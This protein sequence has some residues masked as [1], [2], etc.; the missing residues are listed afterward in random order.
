MTRVSDESPLWQGAWDASAIPAGY[1]TIEMQRHGHHDRSD[2]I[3]VQVIGGA[4]NPPVAAMTATPFTTGNPLS[5]APHGV[6]TN[7]TDR[8]RQSRSR[9]NLLT[10]PG[11]GSR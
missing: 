3:K 11:H 8:R 5:V 7:D 10:G 9:R 6:L 4:T 2:A 1:H